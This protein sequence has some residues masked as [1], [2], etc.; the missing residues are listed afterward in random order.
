MKKFSFLYFVFIT[1]FAAIS[2][3]GKKDTQAK[4][5]ADSLRRVDSVFKIDSV[6]KAAELLISKDTVLDNTA[7]F[8]AGLPQLNSNSLSALQKDKYWVDFQTSMDANW[9]K[10]LDTRLVKM[11]KWEQDVF[12]K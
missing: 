10:M 3:G 7:R 4:K 11:E 9:K 2:C 1:V 12:S 8:M 6:R 5:V